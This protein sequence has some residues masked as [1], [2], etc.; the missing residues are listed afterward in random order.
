MTDTETIRRGLS[1]PLEDRQERWDRFQ[2]WSK[3]GA[4]LADIAVRE[5]GLSGH[6]LTRERVRAILTRARPGSVGR[7]KL[8]GLISRRS[9][10]TASLRY[11]KGFDTDN[12]RSKVDQIS[13]ELADVKEAILVE[14]RKR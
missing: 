8:P 13:V 4:S 2:Q 10:L 7:P 9:A 3:E 5:E 11:W 1:V 6:R 14:R 12:A